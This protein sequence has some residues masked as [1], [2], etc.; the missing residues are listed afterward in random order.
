[1]DEICPYQAAQGKCGW[2]L[3]KATGDH[4]TYCDPYHQDDEVAN[5][6]QHSTAKRCIK[7]IMEE[8]KCK[9][10]KKIPSLGA[11]KL[12]DKE[13]KKGTT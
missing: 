5:I 11:A 2:I 3:Y 8:Y 10:P 6:D 13:K 1:M 12:A 4:R 9:T 7:R